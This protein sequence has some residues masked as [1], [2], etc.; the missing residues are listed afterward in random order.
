[1]PIYRY[2]CPKCNYSIK[3]IREIGE[4]DEPLECPKC[5]TQMQRMIGNVSVK[6]KAKG[7]YS[8]GK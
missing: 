3:K 1:M 2:K 5:G 6:Y 8:T 4:R 7:F